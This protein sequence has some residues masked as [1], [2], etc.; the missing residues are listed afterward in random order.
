MNTI[1]NLLDSLTPVERA[2]LFLDNPDHFQLEHIET[3]HVIAKA[4]T[5]TMPPQ[6]SFKEQADSLRDL[7]L[8]HIYSRLQIDE[9]I[10]I[11]EVEEDLTFYMFGKSD[12]LC[13]YSVTS[14]KRTSASQ[15]VVHGINSEEGPG[16]NFIVLLEWNEVTSLA[17]FILKHKL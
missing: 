6:I 9:E 12:H 17:D 14:L 5:A 11:P 15:V 4:L 10:K 8:R 7:A 3:G 13:A 16:N 1:K 2:I